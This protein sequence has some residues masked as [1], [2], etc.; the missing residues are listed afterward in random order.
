MSLTS[1]ER[2]KYLRTFARSQIR[3]D[4]ICMHVQSLRVHVFSSMRFW[5]LANVLEY[6]G[7]LH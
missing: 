3:M 5:I 1:S 4:E 7:S 6:F 2:P